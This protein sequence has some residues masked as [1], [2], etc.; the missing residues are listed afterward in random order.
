[1]VV[2]CIGARQQEL[3]VL[4]APASEPVRLE[5]FNFSGRVLPNAENLERKSKNDVSA[6][7]RLLQKV[8]RQKN[9][10]AFFQPLL[11]ITIGRQYWELCE[12]RT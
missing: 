1:M 5:V 10:S 6:V 2:L 3:V 8:V 12:I 9:L 11:R 7:G 4:L